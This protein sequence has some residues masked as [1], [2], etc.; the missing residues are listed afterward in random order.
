MNAGQIAIVA[1]VCVGVSA[2]CMTFLAWRLARRR[3]MHLWLGNYVFTGRHRATQLVRSQPGPPLH[4]FIAVCDHYEPEWNNP[5]HEVAVDRV[6]R[7][8]REYPERFSQFHDSR[9]RSPQHTFFFPQDQYGPE[10]L[11]LL[12]ELCGKGFGDVDVH[13]HHDNDTPDGLR[14]KLEGFRETLFHR[15]GLLRRDPVSGEIVYGFIHGNWAL[16]NSR[17]D[18]RWCGVDHEIPIMRETGCYADFTMPSSPSDTQ[19]RTINSIYYA[20]DRPGRRKSHNS[21]TPAQLGTVA[22]ADSLLMIQ[23]PLLLDWR[24][25]KYGVMPGIENGDLHATSLPSWRRFELWRR[26]GIHVVGRPDW[27]F[28]KL[29]THGCKD[30]NIDMLLG[31]RMQSFHRDLAE[32]AQAQ[33]NFQYHYVT[34]WEMAQLVH[35][36]ESGEDRPRLGCLGARELLTI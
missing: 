23:G 33:R 21:G 12:A 3:N 17:P 15:H 27:L 25:R 29:H 6:R 4:V 10:Y 19:T 26:A 1:V 7:W 31:E 24:R 20:K 16:C 35:Q 13:L 5:S 11:D 2:A 36:A 30:G 22:P 28:V 14:D 9:G 8:C 32:Q 34:A 18:G